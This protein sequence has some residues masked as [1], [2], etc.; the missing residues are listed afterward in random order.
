MV[1]I[2]HVALVAGISKILCTSEV[3]SATRNRSAE[4]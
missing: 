4:W 1:S 2:F 3:A